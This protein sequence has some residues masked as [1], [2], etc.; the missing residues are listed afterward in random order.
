MELRD[1]E[2]AL[3]EG[4]FLIVPRGIE[5]RPSANDEVW[6]LLFEP[7]ATVNTG[8]ASGALTVAEPERI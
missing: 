8:N 7:A 4:E 1:R 2:I 3:E 5:H 6:V